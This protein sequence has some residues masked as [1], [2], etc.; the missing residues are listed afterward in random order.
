MAAATAVRVR[1][2]RSLLFLRGSP[3][4]NPPCPRPDARRHGSGRAS[5]PGLSSVKRAVIVS[6]GPT[7]GVSVNVPAG[8]RQRCPWMWKS[9]KLSSIPITWMAT[10]WPTRA[11]IVGVLPAEVRPLMRLERAR[12]AGDRRQE[13]VQ[14]QHLL[15]VGRLGAALAD[16]DRA[17]RAAERVERV[18]RAV[19]VVRPH[20][21]GV[22]RRLPRVR[23]LLAGRDEAAD[24]RVVAE[25][26]PVVVRRVAARRAGAWSAPGRASRALLRKWTTSV[27]PT[28]A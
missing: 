12:Q 22:R 18:V 7:A 8:S 17:E 25:V 16:D 14:E 5:G 21:D 13:R 1:I 20:A 26:D 15:D 28:S 27:S 9:W 19:V 6:F 4:T 10:S 2:L 3:G 23:E 24:A 11:W